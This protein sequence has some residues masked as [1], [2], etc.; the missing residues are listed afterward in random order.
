LK[1][2]Q[3]HAG[4]ALVANEEPTE[5]SKPRDGTFNDSA[6]PIRAQPATD[7]DPQKTGMKSAG[8]AE[9]SCDDNGHN[10]LV[11]PVLKSVNNF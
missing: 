2:C 1:E 5:G 10:L 6:M 9:H 7:K 11:S 4:G 3:E 8:P